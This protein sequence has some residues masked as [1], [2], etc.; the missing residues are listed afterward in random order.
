MNIKRTRHYDKFEM[1]EYYLSVT[2][3][4]LQSRK[5]RWEKEKK[6]GKA[7]TQVKPWNISTANNANCGIIVKIAKNAEVTNVAYS[8]FIHGIMFTGDKKDILCCSHHELQFFSNDLKNIVNKISLP[9]FNALHSTRPTKDGF[10][11]AASGTD[12]IIR[13]NNTFNKVWEWWAIDHG[14][15]KDAYGGTRNLDKNIDHRIF[16]YDTWLHTA[17]IN[18]VIEIDDEKLLAT[19]FME[20]SIIE[21][22]KKTGN[23]KVVLSGLKRPHALR[24]VE[25]NLFTFANTGSGEAILAEYVNGGI[26]IKNKIKIN[27]IWLQDCWLI[28][29]VWYALDGENSRLNVYDFENNLLLSDQYHKDW[30]VY[31]VLPI[32]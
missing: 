18:S 28:N 20:G 11:L 24:N 27:C 26:F 2:Y 10:L 7:K 1:P 21:I 29:K 19:S 32:I 16:E 15:T 4:D 12:V 9:V 31:E 23:S 22:D 25:K 30:Y 6:E 17:H 13:F 3:R 14:Y 5:K 8:D